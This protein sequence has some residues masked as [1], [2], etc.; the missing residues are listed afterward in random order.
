MPPIRNRVEL[1]QHK[2]RKQ[3][4]IFDKEDIKKNSD[5]VK[6]D[7]KKGDEED[8]AKNLKRDTTPM[9][10]YYKDWDKF[11]DEA[12]KELDKDSDSDVDA[13][14]GFIPA[15]KPTFEDEGP[16][17]QAQM[18][19]RTSGAKP[20]TRVVIKGGTIKKNTLADQLKAEG[21][22]LF[23]SLDYERA[24][25]KYT[26]CIPEVPASDHTLRTVVYSNRAQCYIKLKKYEN[27]YAD[28]DKALQYDPSHLKSI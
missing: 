1:D 27:A 19:Q 21:N 4:A 11:A 20:N 17:S 7:K 2:M 28:A 24:V 16:L 13:G 15:T 25:E 5:K 3:Q 10:N 12:L 9:F 6:K 23:A 26:R 8:K 18:L 14:D 22:A